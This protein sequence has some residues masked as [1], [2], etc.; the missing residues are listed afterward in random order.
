M[1]T[2]LRLVAALLLTQ[3]LAGCAGGMQGGVTQQQS[4]QTLDQAGHL[5][6]AS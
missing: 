2:P 4:L 5:G 3:L 1:P 6:N